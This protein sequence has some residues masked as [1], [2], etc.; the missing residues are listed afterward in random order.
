M[1]WE[2]L[3]VDMV[4]FDSCDLE[5]HVRRPKH[6]LPRTSSSFLSPTLISFARLPEGDPASLSLQHAL[7]PRRV[8][9]SRIAFLGW[10]VNAWDGAQTMADGGVGARG[11]PGNGYYHHKRTV[12]EVVPRY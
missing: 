11:L 12:R 5:Y 2:E 1:R 8:A 10:P 6:A 9:D 7:N 4:G 3:I